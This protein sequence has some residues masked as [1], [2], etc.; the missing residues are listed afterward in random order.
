MRLVPCVFSPAPYKR[1]AAARVLRPSSAARPPAHRRPRNR[2]AAMMV[3]ALLTTAGSGTMVRPASAS[4]RRFPGRTSE[5]LCTRVA[6][7]ACECRLCPDL[8]TCVVARSQPGSWRAR[9]CARVSGTAGEQD[10]HSRLPATMRSCATGALAPHP[11]AYSIHPPPST[12][13]FLKRV[14]VPFFPVCVPAS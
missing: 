3:Q 4:A 5:P 12:T 14:R 7:D 10:L 1:Q 8:A 11:L 2:Y 9:S 13:P 6:A